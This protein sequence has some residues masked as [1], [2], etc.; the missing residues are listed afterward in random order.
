MLIGENY[1]IECNDLQFILSIRKV[2]TSRKG[3]QGRQPKQENI[4]K[5]YWIPTAYF[6]LTQKG[7]ERAL[8]KCVALMIAPTELIDFKETAKRLN[9]IYDLIK[10]V[11]YTP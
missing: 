2:V 8:E 9:E 7:L 3:T 6:G 1:K 4:G 5:E 11:R 10:G